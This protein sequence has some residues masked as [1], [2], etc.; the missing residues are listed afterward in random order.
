MM[1][2]IMIIIIII[3]IMWEKISYYSLSFTGTCFD[4]A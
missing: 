1:M 2:M 4:P 3:I